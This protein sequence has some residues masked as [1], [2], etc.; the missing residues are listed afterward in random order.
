MTSHLLLFTIGP[1]QD[2]IAQAR[3]TR[4]LWYGSHLLSELSRAAARS[5]ADA[6]ALLVF[7]ALPRGHGELELCITPLRAGEQPPL[8]IANR[9]LA[10][11]PDGT[12]PERLARKAREDVRRCWRDQI[13]APVK[14]AC[15]RLLADGIEMTW[16]EQ[17]DTLLEFTAAWVPL[18]DYTQARIELDRA[19]AARKHL[20]DFVP[21]QQLRGGV[22]KSS[23]DGARETV[24]ERPERRDAKLVKKYRITD[25]E[26]L[27]A[28]G[29]VK[30]AGGHPKLH[31]D[32]GVDDHVIQFVPVVNVALAPWAL[33]AAKEAPAKL[34]SLKDACDRL[35][36]P[37]VNRKIP[38][39]QAF[40]YDAPIFLQSRWASLLQ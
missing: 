38:C 3:R 4:D 6:G 23:L 1:V 34:H 19:V 37:E 10:E 11:I 33:L 26:Q 40:P 7:P 17:I 16:N 13:A 18:G 31:E 12:D 21:W 15:A 35:G 24:L 9:L 8:N 20:R 27:D 28:V 2:F 30:R 14:R 36:L 5:L 39:A 29:L 32:D 22:P 25:G